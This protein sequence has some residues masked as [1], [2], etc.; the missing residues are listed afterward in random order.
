MKRYNF[1]PSLG[2]L[3]IF[4]VLFLGVLPSRG[5]GQLSGSDTTSHRELVF[6]DPITYSI[7]TKQSMIL[8]DLKCGSDGSIVLPMIEDVSLAMNP[9]RGPAE[10]VVHLVSLTPSGTVLRFNSEYKYGF[11]NFYFLIRN[12]LSDARVYALESAE[13]INPSD[14]TKSL[15]RAYLVGIWDYQG[16]FLS[17]L[18]I[19]PG[20]TPVTV[21]AFASGNI[22]VVSTDSLTHATRLLIFN[23]SGGQEKELRLFDED[24]AQKMS[25]ETNAEARTDTHARVKVEDALST[26]QLV[27]HRDNILMSINDPSFPVLEINEHGIVRSTH[28]EVPD[29]KAPGKLLFSDDR[30]IHMT[31]VT[32]SP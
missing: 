9:D 18:P 5:W 12:Y 31:M 2:I 32:C 30:N 24:F 15:G 29:K 7:G 23:N 6:S 26:A 28:L 8:G 20:I 4:S 27:P 11:R 10:N 14:S 17:I 22:L 13:Q 16:K 19:D 21:A 25:A 1:D 3:F